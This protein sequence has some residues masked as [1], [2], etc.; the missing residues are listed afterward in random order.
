MATK[1]LA[2]RTAQ[3]AEVGLTPLLTQAQVE[4]FY[5][6]SDWTVNQWVK[7]GCPVEQTPFRGRRFDLDR[8]KAWI[9][10]DVAS[11]ASA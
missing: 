7:R 9:S 11:A 5:G 8:V 1:T 10:Q 2:A 6:V 4:A 3:L